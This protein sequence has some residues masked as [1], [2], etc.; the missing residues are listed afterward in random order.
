MSK[1][2]KVA[3]F[4]WSVICN[5]AIQSIYSDSFILGEKETEITA[6]TRVIAE[7]VLYLMARFPAE[8]VIF[9]MDPTG[10]WRH[11]YVEEYYHNNTTA[12]LDK[13]SEGK[14][15]WFECDNVYRGLKWV[16]QTEDWILVKPVTK[17]VEALELGDVE[18]YYTFENFVVPENY[19]ADYHV[20]VEHFTQTPVWE[21]LAPKIRSFKIIPYYKGN[22]N[23]A[24]KPTMPK[25]E[26]KKY[27]LELG[28]RM[29]PLVNGRAVVV[30]KAEADDV[31]AYDI[32]S[33]ATLNPEEN[34]ILHTVDADSYQHFLKHPNLTIFN[35]QTYEEVVLAPDVAHMKLAEKI[36]SGDTSDNI[37]G[38]L[39]KGRKTKMATI[40]WK[41][42]GTIASGKGS[43]DWILKNMKK[44]LDAGLTGTELFGPLYRKMEKVNLRNTWVK[45]LVLVYTDNIPADIIEDIRSALNTTTIV[46]PEFTWD[47]FGVTAAGRLAVTNKARHEQQLYENRAFV[48]TCPAD[49]E[50]VSATEQQPIPVVSAPTQVVDDETF[51]DCESFEEETF[52]EG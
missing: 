49:T 51:E 6:V 28:A 33:R 19:K 35:L 21:A 44:E 39:V 22:R 4:D 27:I 45:N 20:S 47:D 40:S 16:E 3:M 30:P 32:L 13:T 14:V 10:Y 25:D 43:V 38:V 26:F 18:R 23:G 50:P 17:E 42:D 11:D 2:F 9:A 36:I 29:A 37:N 46:S 34:I 1:N 12:Y 8:E 31:Y 7:K 15:W 5:Q 24:W 48:A 52:Q 41:K